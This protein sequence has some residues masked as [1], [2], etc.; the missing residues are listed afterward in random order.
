M[1]SILKALSLLATLASAALLAAC[2]EKEEPAATGGRPPSEPEKLTLVLDYFPNADHA[3][4]YAAEAAGEYERA[5]LDVDIK[6]PPDPSAPLKLLQA[7]RADIAISYEPDVM[8]ARDKGTQLVS[9]GALVQKPLTSLMAL[10]EGGVRKVS[11]LEGKRVGTSGVPYHSAYLKTIL[12][13]AGVDPKSVK[14][15]NVG[16]NLT[17]AMISGKVDATLGAFWNYEGTDLKLRGRKPVILRMEELGVPKYNE[18][19]FVARRE[20]LD[21]EGAS[22]VRR[23]MQATARGHEILRKDPQAAVDAVL[24]ADKGLERRL[25][26]AVVETT[27]PLFFPE[28]DR[29]FGWQEP[30]EWDAYGRWMFENGLLDREPDGSAAMTNEFL[31]GEGLD[32]GTAGLD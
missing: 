26:S 31:P 16:F 7:G 23:F 24:A 4:I 9:V 25:Q 15:V 10:P 8:L 3:G 22:K 6:P 14:E 5:G 32:E 28:G 20:F 1:T 2:G 27:T 18:L 12:T 11:D 19:V 17:P 13:D 29:P 21:E 30:R